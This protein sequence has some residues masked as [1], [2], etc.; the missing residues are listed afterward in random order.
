MDP[1]RAS[2]RSFEGGTSGA[3]EIEKL[4]IHEVEIRRKDLL[5]VFEQFH[6]SQSDWSAR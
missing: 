1:S 3:I 2:G 5:P 4:A 6:Y